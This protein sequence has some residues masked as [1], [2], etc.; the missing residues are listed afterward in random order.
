MRE[1]FAYILIVLSLACKQDAPVKLLQQ[2]EVQLVKPRLMASN[3]IIDSTVILTAYLKLDKVSIFYTDNG[4]EPTEASL[5]YKDAILISAPAT[6]RFKAFHPFWKASE[7]EEIKFVNKGHEVDSIIWLQPLNDQY[8]GQGTRTLVNHSKAN[9]DHMN[10][11]WLGFNSPSAAIFIFVENTRVSSID[12]GYL[13]HPG[14]WIFPP[15]KISIYVSYNGI[16][17]IQKSD[18][19]IA[20]LEGIMD[21]SLETLHI[22][23]K[24]EVKA[25]KISF[26]NVQKLPAW[27]DGAGSSAWLFMD[28]II[29]NK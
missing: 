6:F 17:F 15:D 16:D 11:E 12:I 4:Q 29:F 3:R 8:L 13:C 10:K 20:V 25:I 5:L 26:D 21:A 22:E 19:T 23:V 28:E 24:E 9:N 14:A 18:E 2:N 7:V 27:H 1:M